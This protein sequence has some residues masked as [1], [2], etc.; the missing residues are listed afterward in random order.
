MDSRVLMLAM[1]F[2]GEYLFFLIHDLRQVMMARI[3]QSITCDGKCAGHDM[4]MAGARKQASID[5]STAILF[6]W[7]K[8]LSFPS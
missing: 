4:K 2:S 7:L 6:H 3:D 5:F 8:L 1:L